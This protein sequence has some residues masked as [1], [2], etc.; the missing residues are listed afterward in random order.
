MV[1]TLTNLEN[2]IYIVIQ[3]NLLYFT[4]L[5]SAIFGKLKESSKRSI[6]SAWIVA[7][8][9]VFFHE[10]AHLLVSL[11][12]FGKPSKFSIFPSKSVNKQNGKISYTLGYVISCNIRW[13]NVFVVSMAPLLLLPLSFFI[14]KFFFI[15][16]D[17]NLYSYI[18]YIFIIISLLFSSI[19]SNTDFANVFKSRNIILN[20]V[21]PIMICIILLLINSSIIINI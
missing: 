9:G 16:I 12:T 7:L 15:Y 4:I 6:F 21:P 3:D 11:L 8:L 13:Y 5:I 17:E 2:I 18:L 1:I 19:P 14:Y 10:V 20:L